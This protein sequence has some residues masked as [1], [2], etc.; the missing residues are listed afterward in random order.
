[1]IITLSRGNPLA[2]FLLQVAVQFVEA[3]LADP[4]SLKQ[5]LVGDLAVI[6]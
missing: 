1:M 2:G 3:F 4:H 5:L 6:V